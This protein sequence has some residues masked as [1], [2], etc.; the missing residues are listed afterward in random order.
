[1][2]KFGKNP[3]KCFLISIN[4]K[5]VESVAIMGHMTVA[6]WLMA[7]PENFEV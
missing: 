4:P 1:M 6:R 7:L 5:K 3:Q 2:T